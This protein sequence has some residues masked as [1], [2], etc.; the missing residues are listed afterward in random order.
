MVLRLLPWIE[1]LGP[2]ACILEWNVLKSMYDCLSLRYD[3]R[4]FMACWL[5]SIV[6]HLSKKIGSLKKT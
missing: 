4:M 3:C 5:K 2:I 1:D 6:E